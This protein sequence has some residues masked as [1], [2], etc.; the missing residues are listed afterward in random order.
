[1]YHMEYRGTQLTNR[2]NHTANCTRGRA[3]SAED[4]IRKHVS[5]AYACTTGFINPMVVVLRNCTWM[6]TRCSNSSTSG[7]DRFKCRHLNP[8]CR[9]RLLPNTSFRFACETLCR[10]RIDKNARGSSRDTRGEYQPPLGDVWSI[11]VSTSD[12]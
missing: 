12:I 4:V 11:D 2:R 10:R 9:R 7:P 8:L 3:R 6:N 5:F 1:M